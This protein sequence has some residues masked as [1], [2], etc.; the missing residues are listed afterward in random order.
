MKKAVKAIIAASAVAAV[1]GVAG[2]SFAKW[3]AG[4]TDPKDVTGTTG[5]IVTM[6][7]LSATTD[8][9]DKKLVPYDQEDQYNA[10]TMAQDMT[11]T[12][13]YTGAAG[14][15]IKMQA[16]GTVG[17]KLKYQNG[18]SWETFTT[19]VT[20]TAGSI[21]VR[22]ESEDTGDMNKDWKI[23]FTATAPSV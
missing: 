12:L 11:I 9:G 3:T 1:V 18:G 10:T 23:T 17:G 5:Q 8:L 4:T 14:A 21:K 6:G 22:L 15:T 19:A 13:T 16:S 20:V 2:V 7:E